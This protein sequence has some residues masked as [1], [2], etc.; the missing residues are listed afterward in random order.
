MV[1]QKNADNDPGNH[2]NKKHKMRI[3][4]IGYGGMGSWHC[5]MIGKIEGLELAGIYDILE[6]RRVV[7]KEQ[8]I[9]AYESLEEL[10]ADTSIEIV[11]VAIPNHLHKPVCI[12]AMK[13]G[14]NVVC[15]KPVALNHEEL[16]E[17][18]D[19]ANK[20]HV[21]FTVHQNRRWDEDY[22]IMKHIYEEGTLGKVFRIES[23]VHGSRGIPGDWR[24]QKECGG[25]MVLDWGVHLLDQIMQMIP[26][27]IVSIYVELSYV[28]NE[29]CDDG[30]TVTMKFED[31]LTVVV[32][33]GTSN[34]ISLPR[35][36]MLGENGSAVIEDWS[37]NGKIVM[38]SDWKNREAV[39]VVT[40]AGLTKTMAPRTKDTI[41]EYPLPRLDSDIRE[42]YQNVMKAISG[43]EKQ[44]VTHK[45]LMRVMKL[46]EAVM[47][48]GEK[49]IVIKDFENR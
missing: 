25:G 24:N 18:I 30:F 9:H 11:T 45:E 23:R 22:R 15:E 41:K 26:K 42:F 21:I 38:V 12:Q 40:A 37:L 34:F 13:A 31:D 1:N 4:A 5:K 29:T 39:P 19:A 35:W 47:E 44:L 36:Y 49:N 8:Q 16:Q 10:L 2:M 43:E 46:M 33:V 20:Y 6:E 28:T 27:K 17:M 3:A 14:K 48:S 32:Q 7:A